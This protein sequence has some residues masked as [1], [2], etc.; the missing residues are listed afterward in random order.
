MRGLAIVIVAA[1]VACGGAPRASTTLAADLDAL[2]LDAASQRAPDLAASARSAAA[3]ARAAD[4]R[5]DPAA[6]A[7][8]ATLSRLYAQAAVDE[9]ERLSASEARLLAEREMLEAE[10]ELHA[11]ESARAGSTTELARLAAART[12]REEGARA[13]ARAEIDEAR[14]G[15]ARQDSLS[16]AGEMRQAARAIRD[17]ARLL[18]SAA[19]TL[20]AA[21]SSDVEELIAQSESA[22]APLEAVRLADRA[23]GAARARLAAARRARGGVDAAR[24]ASLAEAPRAR[25][26]TPCA[27]IEERGSSS[28]TCSTDRPRGLTMLRRRG[29]HGSRRWSRRIPTG[30]CAWRSTRRRAPR[31]P[32]SRRVELR[33]WCERS[34]PVASRGRASRP[35]SRSRSMERRRRAR[36]CG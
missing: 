31:R 18:S 8:A 3:D 17:R 26:F 19:T 10:T 2:D 24:I 13:L 30:P 36:A 29:S 21:S 27:S 20:G 1:C 14:P 35:R 11:I 28:S 7:D 33:A 15:R 16:D 12:A 23:H 25:A 5:G 4:D 22:T 34:S 32:T 6:A 9:S